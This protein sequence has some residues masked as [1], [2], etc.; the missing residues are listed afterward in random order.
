MTSIGLIETNRYSR[1]LE[2]LSPLHL[3]EPEQAV[4][5][6][7]VLWTPS[8]PS[9]QTSIQVFPKNTISEKFQP[10]LNVDF[11]G[12]DGSRLS[13]LT[14]VVAHMNRLPYLIRGLEFFYSDSRRSTS[15]GSTNL[16]ERSFFV[17]GAGGERI[18]EAKVQLSADLKYP[19]RIQSLE[20]CKVSLTSPIWYKFLT[21]YSMAPGKISTNWGNT[22][23]FA[24]P[25][26]KATEHHPPLEV[27]RAAEGQ[28]ITGFTVGMGVSPTL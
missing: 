5:V 21:T 13:S 16:L 11:G 24:Y 8:V 1:S 23:I 14:R 17:D 28:V 10:L 19:D 6:E 22:V 2:G 27:L 3:T 20:V 26:V 9:R 4:G 7:D 12:T 25:E 18:N 15:Y